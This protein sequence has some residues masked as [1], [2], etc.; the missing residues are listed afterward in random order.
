ML[1]AGEAEST[2]NISQF[3]IVDTLNMLGAGEI[4]FAQ[5]ISQFPIADT[6]K[7]IKRN[8]NKCLTIAHLNINSLRNKFVELTKIVKG[9]IDV[10][11]I[12]E[13]KLDSSFPSSQFLI[14]GYTSPYRLDRKEGREIGGGILLFVRHD[15]P[16]KPLKTNF[17][18]EGIFVELN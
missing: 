17:S 7:T 4:E 18:K 5:N 15:I 10:I 3:P 1:G 2:Q 16:S 11:L 9:N 12:S 8:N 13:T 14:E 6:L